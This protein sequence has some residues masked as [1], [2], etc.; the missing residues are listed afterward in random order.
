MSEISISSPLGLEMKKGLGGK[1]KIK[2]KDPSQRYV[3]ATLVSLV[4][5][6]IIAFY[7][8]D[9]KGI[10]FG[11]AVIETLNN[12]DNVLRSNFVTFYFY[13]CIK[14]GWSYYFPCFFNYINR[15]SNCFILKF[16]CS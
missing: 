4:I 3:K 7:S 12:K 1:I 9:Y 5:L 6:T 2:S 8:F 15:W 13:A 16:F 14:S 11:K 10:E